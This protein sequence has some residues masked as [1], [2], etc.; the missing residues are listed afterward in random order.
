VDVRLIRRWW[1]TVAIGVLLAVA[2]LPAAA[3]VQPAASAYHWGWVTARSTTVGT[4][5]AAA[6]DRA[7]SAGQGA[8]VHNYGDGKYVVRMKGVTGFLQ[9]GGGG[10]AL[11]SAMG[12]SRLCSI[13]GWY[14]DNNDEK[15]MLSCYTRTGVPAASKFSL[16]FLTTDG[17]GNAPLAYALVE[18]ASAVSFYTYNSGGGATTVT[19]L[20]TGNYTVKFAGLDAA[21]GNVQL[22]SIVGQT[23]QPSGIGENPNGPAICNTVGWEATGTDLEIGVRCWTTAG[24]P[25]DTAFNVAFTQ[26]VGLKANHSRSAYLWANDE[27]A[28]FYKPAAGY[29]YSTSGK[30][31]R[32]TRTAV[33]RYSVDFRGQPSGGAVQVTGFSSV[34]DHCVLQSIA[35]SAPQKVG[36]RCF[37]V[38]GHAKDVQFTLSFEK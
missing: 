27:G 4:Y 1:W 29:R 6:G 19:H 9:N 10:V 14:T 25:E 26:G 20:D 33:G 18:G 16:S 37:D 15:L 31:P 3:S 13:D 12:G 32:I 5:S 30:S 23:F 8:K 34:N 28:S 17:S 35:T 38:D 2:S 22:S 24:D 11:V 7:N 36:V 21:H